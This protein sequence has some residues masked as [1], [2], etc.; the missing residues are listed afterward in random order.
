VASIEVG[1]PRSVAARRR[2]SALLERDGLLVAIVLGFAAC[3][4]F[5]L[6]L[7]VSQDTWLTLLGGREIFRHGLPGSDTLTYW[8]AGKRWIDQQ[9]LAQLAA[10]GLFKV[11]GLKL[12]ALVHVAFVT[13][14]LGMSLLA[15]RVRGASLRT[16][17]WLSLGAV[18][19]LTLSAGHVRA[20]SFAYPLFSVVLLLLVTDRPGSRRVLLTLPLLVVWANVH[21]SVV[22]GATLV[23][24]KGL[25]L[26]LDG[27][28]ERGVHVRGS[29]LVAG[30][31]AACLAS[32]FGLGLV[33]YYR[34][35]LLNPSFRQLVTE[36]QPAKLTLWLVPLYAVA[37]LSFWLLGRRPAQFPSF[38]RLALVLLVAI[39]FL[40][41]RNVVWLALAIVPLL[42]PA[43]DAEL[44]RARPAPVRANTALALGAA[45]FAVV[46]LLAAAARPTEAYTAP[47][48]PAAAEVVARA[49]AHDASLRIF[50]DVR[51]ADWLLFLHPELAGRIAF[52]ARFELLSVK[53]LTRIARWT[54]ASGSWR[55]AIGGA[56]VILIDPGTEGADAQALLTDPGTRQLFRNRQI[57][58]LLRPRAPSA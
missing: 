50:S 54:S 14:A 2:T 52:D 31:A 48:P 55:K 28:R 18:Y 9:W 15:A 34:E 4:T 37:A 32:P 22:M 30:G 3:L 35:T 58:V 8:T 25:T 33:H 29:L 36:W 53:Q 43:L 51:Y 7:R 57:A 13:T 44:P 12:L 6:P 49:A 38:E 46:S 17:A 11:G 41:V 42:A 40:S 27:G 23:A 1:A 21:G 24:T 10:Y 26:V 56:R 39:A 16:V 19:L 20:Q 45:A 47:Y 5:R